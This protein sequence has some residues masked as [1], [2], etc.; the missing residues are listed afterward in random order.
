MYDVDAMST[1][2]WGSGVARLNRTERN[3]SLPI[4]T[5][6]LS[7]KLG[8]LSATRPEEEPQL[9]L[10]QGFGVEME[11]GFNDQSTF[12]GNFVVVRFYLSSPQSIPSNKRQ[13]N[14]A[15]KMSG[16]WN[17]SKLSTLPSPYLA[18]HRPARHPPSQDLLLTSPL[19]ESDAGVF[20]F[21]LDNLGVSGVQFEELVSLDAAS[22]RALSPVYGVIFLFK[23]PSARDDAAAPAAPPD[24]TP[25]PAAASSLFFARQTIQNACGTQALLSVLLNLDA[26]AAPAVRLGPDLAAFKAFAQ[27]LPPDLRGDALSNSERIRDVHN[28]FARASPFAV[29]EP[30]R[31]AEG[32]EED[33]YHFV[34]YAPVRGVLYELDGLRAAPLS[35]G[36]CAFGEFPDKVVPVLRRRVARYPASEIR[37]NLLAMCGDLRV[38]AREA[39]DAVALA[40]EEGRRAE[41]MFENAL[42]R[43]NFV[44]FGAEVLRLAVGEKVREGAF[45][46]WVEGA[47]RATARRVEE[48]RGGEAD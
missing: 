25:D 19:V 41:W 39:G 32:A 1:R 11:A 16:G 23:Y 4:S 21:L 7:G 13:T 40:R 43:H 48:G 9:E 44:G 3:L 12:P 46:E 36:P 27:Q 31:G 45:E 47:R 17:T 2:A 5:R 42:R 28:S 20:T 22:L 6:H 34:A 33:V 10:P 30:P 8:S 38:A 37:F 29:E 26:S 18:S 15:A 24:G 14:R 35:H